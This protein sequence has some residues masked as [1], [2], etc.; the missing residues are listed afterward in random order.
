MNRSNSSV[1]LVDLAIGLLG[2]LV[3]MMVLRVFR[4]DDPRVLYN[5][6]TYCLAIPT[7]IVGSTMLAHVLIPQSAERSIQ[8]GFLLSVLMHL[9]LTVAAINTVLFS[10]VWAR[11]LVPDSTQIPRCLCTR[12]SQTRAQCDRPGDPS[13]T[14]T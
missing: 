8:T 13:R 5:A 1:W 4:F 2:F 7:V 9:G 14:A 11:V 6:W 3:M 10:G 12:L